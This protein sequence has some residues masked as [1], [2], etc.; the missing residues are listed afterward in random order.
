[1]VTRCVKEVLRV[2]PLL[3]TVLVLV[4]CRWNFMWIIFQNHVGAFGE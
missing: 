3:V 4:F 1:M 2:Y